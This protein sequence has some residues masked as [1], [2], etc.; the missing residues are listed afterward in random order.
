MD[1]IGAFD[2]G[3][4]RPSSPDKEDGPRAVFPERKELR[5]LV[6][7]TRPTRRPRCLRSIYRAASPGGVLT[8]D[9]AAGSIDSWSSIVMVNVSKKTIRPVPSLPA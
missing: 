7:R 4:A 5:L 9:F 8:V 6:S 3:Y 2:G 1:Q